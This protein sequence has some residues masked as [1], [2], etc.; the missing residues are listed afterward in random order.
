MTAPKQYWLVY[1]EQRA[2]GGTNHIGT[3]LARAIRLR[4][5]AVVN[6]G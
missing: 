1:Y 2:M 5:N 6:G 4:S 3:T